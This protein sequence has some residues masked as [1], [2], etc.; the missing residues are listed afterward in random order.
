MDLSRI[1]HPLLKRQIRKFLE[2]SEGNGSGLIDFILAVDDT[3]KHHEE[4]LELLERTMAY[5]SDEVSDVNKQLTADLN[6]Q[7]RTTEKLYE[8]LGN[9]GIEDFEKDD[10]LIRLAKFVNKTIQNKQ[11]AELAR[12]QSESKLRSIIDSALDAVIVM[13]QH[14]NITEWNERATYIFGWEKGEVLGKNMSE[15]NI[16]EHYRSTHQRGLEQFIKTGNDR[17]LNKRSEIEAQHKDGHLFPVELSIIPH[18]VD[19][20]Y[21]F[22]SF[23]R[24]LTERKQSEKLLKAINDLALSLLGKNDLQDIAGEIVRKTIDMIGLEDCVIYIL[25]EKDQ[26]LEPVAAFGPRY[27]SIHSKDFDPL[28]VGESIA[29]KVALTGRPVLINDMTKDPAYNASKVERMSELAVPIID[30]N[31]VIGVIDSEHQEKNFFTDEQFIAL[32]TISN[33]T[34]TQINNALNTQKR[35]AAE[36]S[37][38]ESEER[39]QSLIVNQPEAVQISR[40]GEVIY[41]NPAG[42]KLYDADCLEDIVGTNL[43]EMAPDEHKHI[44]KKRLEQLAKTGNIEPIQFSIRTLKGNKKYIEA[45]SAAIQYNGEFAVQTVLRDVTEK[46]KAEEEI[47]QVSSRLYTLLNNLNSGVLMEGPERSVVHC[48][49]RFCELFGGGFTPEDITGMH[50]GELLDKEK[51]SFN[52]P[53]AVRKQ[54]DDLIRTKKKL[55]NQEL[56]LKNGLIY[57]R[58]FIPIYH[59]D[60]YLGNVWQYRDITEKKNAETELLRALESERSYNELNSNFVSMVSHEF[61]TPLTSIHST[62]ELLLQFGERF[63]PEELSKRVDRIYNSSKKMDKLIQDV[64]TVGKLDSDNTKTDPK[65]FMFSDVL[66]EM[67]HILRSS[68]LSDRD[69]KVDL[70]GAQQEVYYDLNLIELILRN[71]LENAGKYSEP[72]TPIEIAFC[73]SEEGLTFSFKDYG[74]G[75]PEQDLNSVFESFKRG[76]NTENFKGTGLGL[77]IVKKAVD[78]MNGEIDLVSEVNKGTI[79]TVQLPKN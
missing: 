51:N 50:C 79:I 59:G 78:R 36:K 48:N 34:S 31:K 52:D 17:F 38:K 67:I 49:E 68:V 66:N 15:L 4:Q 1:S 10:D 55:L 53:D 46:K 18:E 76:S 61:R 7:K 71:L 26:M 42:L 56:E 11:E 44:F 32:S 64:L 39:W 3:Y 60:T 29:G 47:I 41:T 28:R 63:T 65:E 57:E 2:H 40:K 62:A 21:F 73:T 58:D 12:K 33:I 72:D 14:G 23:I 45:N 69:I 74:I 25:D 77:P 70:E 35:L 22:S 37:L 54:T 75:I 13:D 16:A 9:L 5:S 20:N 19:G 8:A 43:S 6:I 27:N 24:D 30:D